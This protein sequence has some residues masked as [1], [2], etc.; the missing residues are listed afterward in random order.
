MFRIRGDNLCNDKASTYALRVLHI[1]MFAD[2]ARGDCL[3]KNM[4]PGIFVTTNCDNAVAS[5]QN[6]CC[7]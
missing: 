7:V 4:R 3:Y 6:N 5:I 2:M 1:S